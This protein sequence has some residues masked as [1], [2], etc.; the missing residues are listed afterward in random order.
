MPSHHEQDYSNP[1]G[2]LWHKLFHILDY[3]VI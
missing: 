2:L 1:L 3:Y